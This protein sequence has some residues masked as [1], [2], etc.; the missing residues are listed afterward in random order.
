M[1]LCEWHNTYVKLNNKL[2]KKAPLTSGELDELI[3]IIEKTK[4]YINQCEYEVLKR[5]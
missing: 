4:E 3:D 2:T 1:N 5:Q